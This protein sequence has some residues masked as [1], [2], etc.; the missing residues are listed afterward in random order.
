VPHPVLALHA[1]CLWAC[2]PVGLW[3]CGLVY[4]VKSDPDLRDRLH[5]VRTP[6][7]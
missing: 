1:G 2:G 4:L 6:S 7:V 5:Q 3:A